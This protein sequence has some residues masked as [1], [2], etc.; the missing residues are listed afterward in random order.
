MLRAFAIFVILSIVAPVSADP[1]LQDV[2]TIGGVKLFRDHQNKRVFYYLKAEKRLAQK[3]DLPDFHFDVNRYIGNVTTD[4]ADAYWIRGVIKFQTSSAFIDTSYQAL[5]DELSLRHGAGID[6]RAAPV[7]DS[8]NKLVFE[9]IADVEDGP[10]SG[11]FDG[12]LITSV[13]ESGGEAPAEN[14]RRRFGSDRQRFTIGLESLDANFFWENFDRDNLI[15]S[16]AYGW[17]VSGVIPDEEDGWTE[18][19]YSVANALPIEVS[20]SK[21]PSLFARNELWQKVKFAHSNVMVMCYDFINV[22]ETDLYYVIVE[23]RFETL[24]KGRYQEKVKFVANSHEYE[25]RIRFQLVNELETGYEYRVQRLFEDGTSADLG[26]Q[27]GDKPFLDISMTVDELEA[28][29]SSTGDNT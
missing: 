12:G 1:N 22:E 4:D 6:L 26:W 7:R 2:T 23:L 16:L 24:G 29:Q 18:S 25:K 20:P 14:K 15:L 28:R 27:V 5:L 3:D 17:D 8:Y 13:D 10:N 19:T 21:Y 9:T 11:E